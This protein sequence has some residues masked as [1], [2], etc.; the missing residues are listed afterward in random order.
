[1]VLL[2]HG[3]LILTVPARLL[4]LAYTIVYEMVPLPESV[5]LAGVNDVISPVREAVINV[6]LAFV[7]VTTAKVLGL[8]FL[9]NDKVEGADKTQTGGVGDVPGDAPG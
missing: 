6:L 8:P 1:M 5:V 2:P 9:G 3:E 7:I 4:P